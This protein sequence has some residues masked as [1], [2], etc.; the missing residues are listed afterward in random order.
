MILYHGGFYS[1]Y[2][3]VSHQI[4]MHWQTRKIPPQEELRKISVP[5]KIPYKADQNSYLQTEGMIIFEG[6]VYRAM[7]QKYQSDSLHI[8]AV[9]DRLTAHLNE[10]IHEWIVNANQAQE[11][12]N[13]SSVVINCA[14]YFDL[15]TYPIEP[16]KSYTCT[17]NIYPFYLKVYKVPDREPILQPPI[18]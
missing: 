16:K 6:K 13:R 17:E 11:E 5:M 9:E 10:S 1:V 3:L 15:S 18:V 14:K 8:L 4:D 2:W 7:Y 12:K